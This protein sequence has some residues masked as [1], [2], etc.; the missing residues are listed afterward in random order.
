MKYLTKKK[1]ILRNEFLLRLRS[2]NLPSGL[3][4]ISYQICYHNCDKI[5]RF[6]ASYE[7]Y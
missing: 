6:N 7:H 3:Y 5:S 1:G 2:K 4:F